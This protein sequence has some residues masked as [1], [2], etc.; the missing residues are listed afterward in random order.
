MAVAEYAYQ[1]AY[2]M[3]NSM[4][5]E[6]DSLRPQLE[7]YAYYLRKTEDAYNIIEPLYRD[8][9]EDYHYNAC[10][11]LTIESKEFYSEAVG[12][13]QDAEETYSDLYANRW[14]TWYKLQSLRTDTDFEA[15]SK[16]LDEL[17]HM[18]Q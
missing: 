12:L 5:V 13:Q 2:D 9:P 1:I 3:Q 7:L 10:L 17:T 15:I 18:T 8:C 16:Q 14:A 6:L 4:V 11:N